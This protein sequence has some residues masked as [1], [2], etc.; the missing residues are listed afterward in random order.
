VKLHIDILCFHLVVES[1]NDVKTSILYVF[2]TFQ[3][4]LNSTEYLCLSLYTNAD[5]LDIVLATQLTRSRKSNDV[6]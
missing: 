3:T 1:K 4:I 5:S 2:C 6:N